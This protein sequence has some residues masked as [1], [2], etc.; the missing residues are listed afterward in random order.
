VLVR[1]S[2]P[3][4]RGLLTQSAGRARDER[5]CARP[6][7]FKS[8]KSQA[9]LCKVASIFD[10]LWRGERAFVGSTMAPEMISG[11][12]LDLWFV[13]FIQGPV[14]LRCLRRPGRVLDDDRLARLGQGIRHGLGDRAVDRLE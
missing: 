12:L 14:N 8:P 5:G 11:R 2:P 1:P 4:P 7:K 3:A 9:L 10:L 13:L 6:R